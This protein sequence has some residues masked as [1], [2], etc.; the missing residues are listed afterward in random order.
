MLARGLV[1]SVLVL[2]GGLVVSV[3]PPSAPVLGSGV[4]ETL[5]GAEAGRM[6]ALTLV[7][8]GLALLASAWLALCRQVAFAEAEERYDA[9]D[10]VRF[11]TMV[12]SAPLVLA[13]P[14]FSRD[15]WS[16]AAQGMLARLGLSP[17]EHGP[18]ALLPQ[19]E[20]AVF[21]WQPDPIV[22]A[23]DP[24]WMDTATPYGPLP[25]FFGE[26]VARFTG[27][28]WMLA[29]AHRGLA[30]VGLVLLA[31]AVPRLA[32]W[33]GVNPALAS[34]LVL[35]SPLMIANGVGGLHNDL[36]MVGLMAAALVVGVERGWMWGAALGGVA[37]AVKLPGGL[38]CLGVALASLSVA[39][40]AWDRLRRMLLVAGVALGTLFGLG[41]ATGLGHGW[42]AAL[43]VP[44]SINT[45][46]SI[47]TLSG[48][49][50]D[51]FAQQLGLGLEPFAFRDLLRGVG[52][53]LILGIGGWVAFRW[54]TG[55]RVA[56]IGA[57]AAVTAA[58]VVLCPV[59][60]LWYF[61]VLPPFLATQ[62][63]SRL[64]MSTLL[65][66]SVILGLVAPLD[67]S[68]HG[69][70]LAI[71]LGCMTVAVLLPLLLLTRRA[72][73]RIGRIASSRGLLV[74]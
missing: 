24:I 14:L 40:T 67:S 55:D 3:L 27:N 65:S 20:W 37:A 34:A 6:S 11:A 41:F 4:L 53:L 8:I 35:V 58:F 47:T 31:W 23:V 57:V 7:L 17:Y 26:I 45:P 39:A 73:Q 62:Q 61:L 56:S 38:V 33:T 71:I 74:P 63:L 48:G 30:L 64:A 5:R 68:L 2:L 22:Q 66:A 50:L 69:A 52:M 70:Y 1:G 18:A 19:G 12:W 59:V 9:L 51:W 16:Y 43:T 21:K 42:I 28:P 13:P 10:L 32:A 44:G 36:L 60:H 54:R 29:I 49:I 72:R 25:V 46:L 15:G